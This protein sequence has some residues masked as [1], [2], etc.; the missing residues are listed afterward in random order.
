MS[1]PCARYRFFPLKTTLCLPF[2]FLFFLFF[3]AVFSWVYTRTSH[4]MYLPRNIPVRFIPA[5]VLFSFL[6]FLSRDDASSQ[7]YTAKTLP[8]SLFSE[9]LPRRARAR[10]T[11]PKCTELGIA[12]RGH[13]KKN[14]IWNKLKGTNAKSIQIMYTDS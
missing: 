12:L 6:F 10:A 9:I 4:S 2:F 5:S 7:T 1:F 3:L 13:L 11:P 14:F 8:G